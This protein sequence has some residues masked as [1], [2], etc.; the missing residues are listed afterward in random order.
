MRAQLSRHRRVATGQGYGKAAGQGQTGSAIPRT[1]SRASASTGGPAGR[2]DA[3]RRRG[4]RGAA[5]DP[6]RRPST[7]AARSRP[8]PTWPAPAPTTC[9]DAGLRRRDPNTV[10]TT[11]G[12][13]R[14]ALPRA[15]TP[16]ST[17]PAS[18]AAR[19]PVR[20]RARAA[21]RRR[22]GDEPLAVRLTAD[23]GRRL[24]RRRLS[25]TVTSA[26][27]AT[28]VS[29]DRDGLGHR[30]LRAAGSRRRP[31]RRRH[32]RSAHRLGDARRLRLV[33][34][35]ACVASSSS[36]WC[37]AIA[38]A[39]GCARLTV[40]STVGRVLVPCLACGASARGR[41]VASPLLADRRTRRFDARPASR[42]RSEASPRPGRRGR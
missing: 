24:R 21:T 31:P 12:L 16:T 20:R 42:R 33:P 22:L 32:R 17:A 11:R 19:L 36:W 26:S 25:A 35:S 18:A 7:G 38:S 29:D 9:S 8:P 10:P 40:A 27:G 23:L 2:A 15:R 28:T 30:P 4:L 37:A 5:C 3:R 6:R 14:P 34:G 39:T 1:S 13:G 41:L